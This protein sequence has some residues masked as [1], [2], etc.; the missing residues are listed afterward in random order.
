MTLFIVRSKRCKMEP[1]TAWVTG[2]SRG[3]G[4]AIAEKLASTG[5]NVIL[6]GRNRT[7]LRSSGEGMDLQEIAGSIVAQY[8]VKCIAVCGELTEEESVRHC[9]AGCG[10]TATW[11]SGQLYHSGKYQYAL[12]QNTVCRRPGTSDCQ[13]E[14][15]G[16]CRRAGGY[17]RAGRVFV[18]TWR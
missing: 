8:H 10:I 17:C 16:T 12:Y 18:R 14:P 11:H 2:S 13:S 1:R 6:H 15:L 5:V 3:I 9:I 4:R 7:N